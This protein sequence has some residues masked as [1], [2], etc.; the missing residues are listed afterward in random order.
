M[1]KMPSTTL[2]VSGSYAGVAHDVIRN[3]THTYTHARARTHTNFYVGS[4]SLVSIH[5]HPKTFADASKEY[6]VSLPQPRRGGGPRGGRDGGRG[7]GR[8][9][10]K[11]DG[12]GGGKGDGKDDRRGDGK[13]GGRDGRPPRTSDNNM[14]VDMAPEPNKVPVADG[15]S[16]DRK[17]GSKISSSIIDVV[18]TVL[19]IVVVTIVLVGVTVIIVV[20]TV[21]RRRSMA[22]LKDSKDDSVVDCKFMD[23]LGLEYNT[24]LS[25]KI[26]DEENENNGLLGGAVVA[27]MPSDTLET[28]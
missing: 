3:I 18:I 1:K 24:R 5:P 13:D 27:P 2:V 20:K 16:S 26:V 23:G 10:G 22:I 12:R 17:I 4:I 19:L 6:V 14:D 7:D 25:S 15:K 9:G 8:G 28:P 11:D 21:Q